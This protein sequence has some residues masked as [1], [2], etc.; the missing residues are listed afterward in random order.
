MAFMNPGC[1]TLRAA[2]GSFAAAKYP[3]QSK[4]GARFVRATKLVLWSV[5]FGS[6][7]ATLSSD[8]TASCFSMAKTASAARREAARLAPPSSTTCATWTRYFSRAS[9]KRGSFFT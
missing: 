3:G 5:A 8:A 6:R 9:W 2:R 7:S 4:F 1:C